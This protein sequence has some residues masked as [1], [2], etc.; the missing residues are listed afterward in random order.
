MSDKDK[1]I[2]VP[3]EF[4]E[5]LLMTQPETLQRMPKERH[6]YI[7][8]PKEVTMQE[9]RIALVPSSI[10]TLTARGHRVVVEAGAGERSRFP[11]HDYSESGAEIVYSQEEVYKADI[12]IRWL[13][14]HWKKST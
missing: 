11:D 6:L 7:G 12:I 14:L 3:K 13:L 2:P 10:V 8:I 9:N 1:K 5:G 4:T